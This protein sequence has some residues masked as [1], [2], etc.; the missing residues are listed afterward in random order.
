MNE[1]SSGDYSEFTC[2][3]HKLVTVMINTIERKDYAE[4]LRIATQLDNKLYKLSEW[5]L[6]K[7]KSTA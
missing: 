5:L 2:D 1:V 4:G 7:N 6:D 3:M